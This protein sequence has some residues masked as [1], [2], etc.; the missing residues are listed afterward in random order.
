MTEENQK[1]VYILSYVNPRAYSCC[2]EDYTNVGVYSSVELAK[3]AWITLRSR[4]SFD[5][6]LSVT[7]CIEK[8]VIDEIPN[9]DEYDESRHLVYS[10]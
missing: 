3:I 7:V 8:V 5:S 4:M 10:G 1:I 2:D 9:S 6:D